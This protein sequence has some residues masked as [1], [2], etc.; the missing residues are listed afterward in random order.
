MLTH[1][2]SFELDG[3]VGIFLDALA[4]IGVHGL[5]KEDSFEIHLIQMAI[6]PLFVKS[7]ILEIIDDTHFRGSNCKEGKYEF[8][9]TKEPEV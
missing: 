2:K 8:Q 3:G 1:L 4:F 7:F 9:F 6:T 5:R